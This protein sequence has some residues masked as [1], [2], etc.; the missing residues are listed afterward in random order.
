MPSS[1]SV[2]AE[3]PPVATS[4][5][6]HASPA[7]RPLTLG[8]ALVV[9]GSFL[10]WV[11]TGVGTYGGMAGAGVWTFYAGA[12]GIGAGLV[13]HRALARSQAALAGATAVGL[14]G[15]QVAHLVGRV[16]LSGWVPGMGLVLVLGGG[17]VA[18]GA[19]WRMRA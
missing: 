5:W 19:A 17:V 3:R 6:P 11:E 10:P 4:R 8:A 16:G 18:L 7:Q 15:W 2:L 9:L 12:L 1:P 14:A 13:R